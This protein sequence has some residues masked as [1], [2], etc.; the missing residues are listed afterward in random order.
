MSI[1]LFIYAVRVYDVHIYV[2]YS[3]RNASFAV[4]AYGRRIIIM[5]FMIT[6]EI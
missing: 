5:F 1:P 2:L 3:R 6:G 4:N